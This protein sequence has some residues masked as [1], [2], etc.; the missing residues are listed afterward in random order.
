MSL[1]LLTDNQKWRVGIL[2]SNAA[3][4]K[5]VHTIHLIDRPES[6]TKNAFGK[7]ERL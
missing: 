2:Q 7:T 3:F 1:T 4:V 5:S 6:R